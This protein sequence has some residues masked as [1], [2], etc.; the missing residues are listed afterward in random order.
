MWQPRRD[1]S[2]KQ[3]P[4]S[5]D[6]DEAEARTKLEAAQSSLERSAAVAEPGAAGA[7]IKEQ[8]ERLEDYK[9]SVNEEGRRAKKSIHF[10]NYRTQKKK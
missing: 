9:R 10:D 4:H 7:L 1:R 2:R 8:K 6:G 3:W 5:M